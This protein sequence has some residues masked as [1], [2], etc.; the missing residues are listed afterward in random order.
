M[1][2]TS[3]SSND[4][5]NGEVKAMA[6]VFVG[7]FGSSNGNNNKNPT[8]SLP[9]KFKVHQNLPPPKFAATKIGMR[10]F[11]VSYETLMSYFFYLRILRKK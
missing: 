10:F 2:F 3:Y 9:R 1:P 7:V 5:D 6:I 8:H 4:N 11:D